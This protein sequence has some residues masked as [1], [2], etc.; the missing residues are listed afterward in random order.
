[1]SE[2]DLYPALRGLRVSDAMHHGLVSCPLDA[3]LRSVARM[4]ATHR[5]HAILVISHG[6]HEFP[7]GHLW[8]VISDA[9]LLH[10]AESGDLEEQ[11]AGSVAL[12]PPASVRTTDELALAARVLADQP[13]AHVIVVDPRSET[14]V[15]VLSRLDVVRALAGFPERHPVRA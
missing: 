6:E 2:T 4:M 7:G 10:A 1:M 8:G 9:E 11:T 13:A 12:A 5:V 14:P 15:G 3:P